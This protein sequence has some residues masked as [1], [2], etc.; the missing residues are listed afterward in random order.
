MYQ[1]NSRELSRVKEGGLVENL[2]EVL[3]HLLLFSD[4]FPE[5][6]VQ[7]KIVRCKQKLRELLAG[8]QNYLIKI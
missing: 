7:E 6:I 8:S 5:G 2:V 3:Q 1:K 4:G